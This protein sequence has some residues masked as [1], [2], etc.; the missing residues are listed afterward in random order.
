MKDQKKILEVISGNLK[1]DERKEFFSG[2]E[3]NQELSH[4][5]DKIKNAWA[6]LASTKRMPPAVLENLYKD[7]RS[8]IAENQKPRLKLF[9]DMWK[10]AAVFVLAVGLTSVLF[11]WSDRHVSLV[12][13]KVQTNILAENGQISKVI[14]PDSSVVW[15]NSGSQL[16]Y[17]T[18]YSIVNRD[19]QLTGQAFFQVAKNKNLPFKVKLSDLE[20]KVLGTRFDVKGYSGDNN[21]NVVLEEGKVEL[22][23]TQN[24]SFRV[25]LVPGEMATYNKSLK[26]LTTTKIKTGDFTSWKEGILVFREEPMSEVIPKLQRRYNIDIEVVNPEIYKS[27]YTAKI[28]NESLDELFK[29]IGFASAIQY[30]IVKSDNLNSRTKVILTIQ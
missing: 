23:H 16:T 24:K 7:F 26:S 1:N 3:T 22:L 20:V 25:E 9:R 29:S 4:E 14:L 8:Q 11:F 5:F 17:S 28:T 6:L 27:V 19:V 18:N 13:N 10:Y 12:E 2:L 21:I 30:R 15:L